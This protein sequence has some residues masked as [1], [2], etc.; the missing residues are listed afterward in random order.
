MLSREKIRMM[1]QAA[2]YEKSY[3]RKDMFV[4]RYFKNDY[5]GLERLKTKIWMTVFFVA[6]IAAYIFDLVY[7]EQIDLLHF[8][9]KQFAIKAVIVYLILS[10]I[11]S[12]LTSAVYGPKYERASRRMKAYYDQLEKI[13][14]KG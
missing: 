3:Y 8:N 2:V 6:Y 11:I 7:I 9:Y 5:I 1:A 4:E 10:V 14:L 13:N 12:V